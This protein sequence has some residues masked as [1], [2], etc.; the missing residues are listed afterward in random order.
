MY[1]THLFI[2]SSQNFLMINNTY[3]ACSGPALNNNLH[4]DSDIDDC[5]LCAISHN[6]TGIHILLIIKFL[7]EC[8]SLDTNGPHD[9]I[10]Y[11]CLW[12]L[13][14]HKWQG[15]GWATDVSKMMVSIG[16]TDC[17]LPLQLITDTSSSFN[18]SVGWYVRR[19][20]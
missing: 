1:N 4:A 18:Y 2:H 15:H 13:N 12:T 7:L 20:I 17:S 11:G 9:G 3:K 6:M 10:G 8:W 19:R 5:G 16:Y 14:T